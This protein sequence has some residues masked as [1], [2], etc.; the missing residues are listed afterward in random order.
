MSVIDVELLRP[1]MEAVRATRAARIALV[2]A[3]K[4][5]PEPPV[6]D[7]AA[8]FMQDYKA[9]IHAHNQACKQLTEQV[10]M[11]AQEQA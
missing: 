11:L 1:Y 10:C 4:A 6:A 2:Y 9:A 7:Q 3:L 5:L 8:R